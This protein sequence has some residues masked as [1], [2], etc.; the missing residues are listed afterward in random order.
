MQSRQPQA[1]AQAVA[2]AFMGARAEK[3]PKERLAGMAA[4]F[5]KIGYKATGEWKEE[6]VFFDAGRND[7]PQPGGK[8]RCFAAAGHVSRRHDRP[9]AADRDPRE[10]FADWLARRQESLVRAQHR[11]SRLVLAP[12]PRHHPRAGRHPRR[13]TRRSIPSCWPSWSRSWSRRIT[14]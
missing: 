9:P 3:W 8:G 5:A 11:Q 4:F 13:T 6:I 10:V 7:R 1:I 12:G 2:L 14:T